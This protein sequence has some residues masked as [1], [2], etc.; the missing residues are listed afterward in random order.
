MTE[1]AIAQTTLSD[2]AAATALAGEIRQKLSGAPDALI[3]FASPDNDASI[4]LQTLAEACGT[5]VIV[6]CTSAGEFTNDGSGQGL[7]NVTAIR[8][9]N[10]QFTVTSGTNL[11]ADYR[12]AAQNLVAGF[13]AASYPQ[14]PFRAALILLDALAGHAEQLI[15]ALTVDTA[16]TYRFFG[17]GAGDDGRFQK[18]HVFCGTQVLTDAAVALEILSKR[19]V[20][21]G[22]RHGWQTASPALRVTEADSSHVVSLNASPAVE[23]F[24]DHAE[25]TSQ[26]FDSADPLPFFLHN[27]VGVDTPSGMKLRVPLGVADDGAIVCAAEIPSGST[28]HIMSTGD[29]SAVE[30]A[31]AATRDAMDQVRR[32]GGEPKAALFFDCVATRLRLGRGFDD[33]L[34]AVANEL[35]GIPFAGF[36]SYGQV[37]RSEGQ[38][39]GFHNCTAVVCVLP[40]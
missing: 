33:E 24:E 9:S 31:A 25:S 12:G 1:V 26:Q 2:E 17:G 13:R 3:V 38:F 4:L 5:D 8:A 16:G 19:P 35:G 40:E 34:T 15:D 20:G 21:I 22:A 37:V 30:A 6:G 29:G 28:T 14:F 23:A 10:I 36:N 32:E 18:T 39:S 27:I 7:T 11:S